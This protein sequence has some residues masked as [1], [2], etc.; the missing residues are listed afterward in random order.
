[1]TR[2][3]KPAEQQFLDLGLTDRA[4]WTPAMN[5]AVKQKW[6]NLE[7]DAK[8]DDL[9]ARIA[10]VTTA[11]TPPVE[12]LT[13][14]GVADPEKEA[15]RLRRNAGVNAWRVRSQLQAALDARELKFA[16]LRGK[17]SKAVA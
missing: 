2:N 4:T 9:R 7:V 14:Q 3:S 6:S 1:M 11:E 8:V 15:A 17:R 12:V 13:A 5:L 16:A 10:A